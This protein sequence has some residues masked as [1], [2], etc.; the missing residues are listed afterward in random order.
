MIRS[1]SRAAAVT[2]F[3]ICAVLEA[4]NQASTENGPFEITSGLGRKL[5][6]LPDEDGAIAAAKKSLAAD[7]KNPAL[8]LKLSKVEAAKQQ[9]REAVATCSAGLSF[10]PNDADLY[11]ERG[12][13]EL[14]LR[15]FK[16]GLADL[17]RAV[18][19][20]PEKLDAQYHLGM[21]HYFLREFQ[22]AAQG[23]QRALD[24]AKTSDSII[25]CSNWA[26]VSLRRAGETQAAAEV[27]KRI[28]PEM[29][30]QEPH[31]LFYLRLLR[32]YQGSISERDVAPARP[33]DQADVEAEL[34][35]DT[36]SYGVGNWHLYNKERVLAREFFGRVVT[37]NA[38][39]AW[40]FIGS[41][42]ELAADGR[43]TQ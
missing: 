30:N 41:E 29:K 12:H 15:E 31:L 36:V 6:A 3:A 22:P 42:L 37:G 9:Y 5:Y 24:L 39:N 19:L 4:Q 17:H 28:T 21:A 23:F 33:A 8:C 26:Y 18:E 7:P 14:G 10:A 34:S 20:D 11:L 35:F 43:G 25:D 38:W 40:G 1:M 2:I 13:R 27:L 16:Q 32:F